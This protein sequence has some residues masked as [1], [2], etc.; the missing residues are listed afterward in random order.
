MS[1]VAVV[2]STL[3]KRAPETNTTRMF[4]MASS[5]TLMTNDVLV[6]SILT[7][8]KKQNKTKQ[9]KKKQKKKKQQ[10]QS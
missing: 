10:Q 1:F 2:I 3:S 8:L 9:N 7:S 5:Q 6:L 4:L